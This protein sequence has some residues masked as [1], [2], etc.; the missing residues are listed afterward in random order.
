[1]DLMKCDIFLLQETKLSLSSV[2][3]LFSSWK[4]WKFVSSPAIGASG[5]LAL[6]WNDYMVELNLVACLVN[7]MLGL[8]KSRVSNVK[9]WIFNIYG[10][11]SIL[12]KRKFWKEL[13]LV[14]SP[15][16][17]CMLVLGGDFN[18][19]SDLDEKSSG[20]LANHRIIANFGSFIQD[21]G[22]FDCKTQNGPFTWMNMRRDF[23]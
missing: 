4:L 18:A 20:F 2:S 16:K 8:V 11:S 22:L 19:I 5:G 15:L 7:W 21:M 1:M 14:S 13:S 6:L 9:F 12:E 23:F 10:P 17:D 3:S